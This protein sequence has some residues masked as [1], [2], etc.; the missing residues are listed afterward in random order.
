MMW[1]WIMLKRG[2]DGAPPGSDLLRASCVVGNY[3]PVRL[4]LCRHTSYHSGWGLH[5]HSDMRL[6]IV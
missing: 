3:Y 1:A 6:Y 2:L 5:H 4:K